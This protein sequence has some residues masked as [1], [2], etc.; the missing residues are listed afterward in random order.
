M[1]LATIRRDGGTAAVRVDGDHAVEV[2]QPDVGALLQQENW[3]SHAEVADGRRHRTD[4][5]AYAPLIPRPPK[6]VCVGLNY[7]KHILEV[8]LPI[9]QYPTL[10]AKYPAALIGASDDIHMP[11]ESQQMD[12]EAELAVVVGAGGRRLDENAAAAVIAGFTVANDISARDWQTRTEEWM[13]GKTFEA[14]NPLGPHLVTRDEA[15]DVHEIVCEVDGEVMQ[16][17]DTADLV[18]GPAALVSYVSQILPL[19][20]G[21]VILTGTPGGVGFARSPQRWLADGEVVTTRI[22]GIGECRNRCRRV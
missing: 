2:G 22:S 10:F 4:G 7:R 13:Q 14:T 8:G 17:A 21:D 16:R 19:E 18:F 5:L 6:I 11:P 12:W 1:R 3:R 20:P 15:G 9:P